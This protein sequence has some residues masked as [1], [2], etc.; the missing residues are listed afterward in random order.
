M[1]TC[2]TR[3]RLTVSEHSANQ[4]TPILCHGVRLKEAAGMVD[5]RFVSLLANRLDAG[6]N[7]IGFGSPP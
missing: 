5:I 6:E 2:R 4:Q 7:H 3:I 1:G